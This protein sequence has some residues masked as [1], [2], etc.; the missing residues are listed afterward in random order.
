VRIE[1]TADWLP[2]GSYRL[3]RYLPD[4]VGYDPDSPYA[5]SGGRFDDGRRPTLYLASSPEGAIA[6]FL[7]RHP[8]LMEFQDALRIQVFE[9]RVRVHACCLDV[10]F[11]DRAAAAGIDL[12]RLLSNDSDET[13]RYEYSREVAASPE[14]DAGI[15]YPSAAHAAPAWCLVLFGPEGGGWSSE[16]FES[17]TRPWVNPVNVSTIPT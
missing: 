3:Y 2:H 11:P 4:R 5:T 16:G 1:S 7:R 8:E 17:V 15:A 6:E 14:I 10:R 13:Q 12:A 9:V